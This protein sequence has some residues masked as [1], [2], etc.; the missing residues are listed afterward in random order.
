MSISL[1]SRR[2]IMFSIF[3]LSIDNST[4]IAIIFGS[5]AGLIVLCVLIFVL[6]KFV[7]IRQ[8]YKKQIKELDRLYCYLDGKLRGHDSQYIHRLEIISQTNLLYVDLYTKFSKRFKDVLEIDD[9]YAESMIK[10]LNS[11]IENR[12][13]KNLK[14]VIADAKK[15]LSIF[16]KSVHELDNQLEEVIKPEEE[17]RGRIVRLKESYRSVKQQYVL[18]Q[19]DL[20]LVSSSFTT[21]FNRLDNMFKSFDEHIDAAEYE[22]ANKLIPLI[23]KVIHALTNVLKVLPNLCVLV[24]QVIPEKINALTAEFDSFDG[25]GLPLYHLSFKHH[26]DDWNFRLHQ[27][28]DQLVDLNTE[29]VQTS[30]DAIIK[31]INDITNQLH[32]EVEDKRIFVETHENVYKNVSNLEKNFLKLIALL[33]EVEKIY[34]VTDEKKSEIEELKDTINKLGSIKRALDTYVHSSTKQPFSLLRKKLDELKEEYD[35]ANKGVVEFKNYIDSLK[36]SSEEA[37]SLVF[38]YYYRC[39]QIEFMLRSLNIPNIYEQYVEQID[40]CYSLL[41]DI[42]Q[43]LKLS[44]IDVSSVNEKVAQLRGSANQ[45]FDTVENMVKQAKLAESVVVYANRD[46]HHQVDVHKQLLQIENQFYNGEFEQVYH[47]ASQIYK[48]NHVEESNGG[49]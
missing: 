8:R 32:Q 3:A 4:L 15:A 42:D 24:Q 29:N 2:S 14:S 11:L 10:Q 39:K 36:S 35:K 22:E 16:E 26:L 6:Y 12:Q 13:Y 7:F 18:S 34:I 19:T 41:S 38:G 27:I 48:R 37:Y 20:E 33:P 9:K 23:E 21:V 5:V 43:M 40:L 28:S 31:E 1:V 30:C 25:Q 44:P 17:S 45:F 49:E 46:R 47:S